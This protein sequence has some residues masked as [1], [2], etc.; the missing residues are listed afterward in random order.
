MNID[1]PSS[2][3]LPYMINLINFS[4]NGSIQIIGGH[5]DG[6]WRRNDQHPNRKISQVEI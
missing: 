3:G 6:V 1:G 5:L 4:V 2:P